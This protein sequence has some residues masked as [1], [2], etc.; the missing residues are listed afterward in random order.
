MITPSVYKK[1][2]KILLLQISEHYKKGSFVENLKKPLFL[3]RKKINY[4][5]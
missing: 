2:K 3:C 1:Y 4:Y 5:H